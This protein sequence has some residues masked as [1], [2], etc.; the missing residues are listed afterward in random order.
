MVQDQQSTTPAP[1]VASVNE[2]AVERTI[3]AA[4]R[5]LMSWTRTSISLI[6]FGF[7]IYKFLEYMQSEG[8]AIVFTNPNGPKNF[9]IALI[10]IGVVALALA[11]VQYRSLEKRLMPGKTLVFSLS[12][13]VAWLIL[14][15]G[16]LALT[17]IFF[18]IGPF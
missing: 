1:P 3:M 8:K 6:S 16:F 2:L 10:L 15:L 11:S 12:F 4:E 17:N 14:L 9:G 18:G 13:S 7:T 5:T